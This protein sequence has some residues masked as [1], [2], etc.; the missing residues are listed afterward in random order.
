MLEQW[1]ITPP[2]KQEI[3]RLAKLEEAAEAGILSNSGSVGG[4]KVEI[5]QG[6]IQQAREVNYLSCLLSVMKW[7]SFRSERFATSTQAC[8]HVPC[9]CAEPSKC[10]DLPK[11]AY[12]RKLE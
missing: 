10:F 5:D 2:E 9:E 8:P 3:E 12:S 6:A 4:L 7:C 1:T 11:L